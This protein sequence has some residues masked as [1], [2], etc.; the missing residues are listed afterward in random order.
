MIGSLELC[1]AVA[2][3][4]FQRRQC[5]I[6]VKTSSIGATTTTVGLGIQFSAVL[7]F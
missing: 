6:K 7:R 2:T 3:H 4:E 5:N 1:G